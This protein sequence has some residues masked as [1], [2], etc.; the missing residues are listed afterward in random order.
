MRTLKSPK[1]KSVEILEF[2]L[3]A[4]GYAMAGVY[5]S[6]ALLLALVRLGRSFGFLRFSE[7]RSLLSRFLRNFG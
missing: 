1:G 5:V 2:L 4:A 7:N 3:V 6:T